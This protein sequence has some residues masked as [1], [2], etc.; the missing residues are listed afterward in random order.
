[1]KSKR[2]ESLVGILLDSGLDLV[3][4]LRE[5]AENM[6]DIKGRVR[7]TYATASDRASRAA[8]VLRG[9]EDSQVLGKVG[10]LLIGVGIGVGIGLLIAPASGQETRDQIKDTISDIRHKAGQ[11]LE[12]T[13]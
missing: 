10:A 9:E 6:D 7:N 4:W 12:P 1:M 2:R 3:D 5:R 11:H 8:D 13:C